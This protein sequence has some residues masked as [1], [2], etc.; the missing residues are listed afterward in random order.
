MTLP[1]AL[2]WICWLALGTALAAWF[3]VRP[4]SAERLRRA[5]E[6]AGLLAAGLGS[7]LLLVLVFVPL[8]Y[9]AASATA[10]D[11]PAGTTVTESSRLVFES[12]WETG[13][14]SRLA[15]YLLL[16]GLLAVWVAVF[17]VLHAHRG[18]PLALL[19]LWGAT[20]SLALAMVAGTFSI[21]PALF[22]AVTLALAAAIDGLRWS[23][24][25]RPRHGH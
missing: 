20:A 22:P 15:V 5:E 25:A 17:A 1:I 18:Q 24:Q 16:T 3:L 8:P 13:I 21:G 19:L 12:L 4:G 14:G 7:A 2:F 6:T 10:Q 11:T 9:G 23:H